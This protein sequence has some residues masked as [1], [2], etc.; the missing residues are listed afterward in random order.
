MN[1][2]DLRKLS[3]AAT[4]LLQYEGH[5]VWC[6]YRDEWAERPCVCGYLDAQDK[7]RATLAAPDRVAEL[8]AEN[9]RL[10][11][12]L[13]SI[14]GNGCCDTCQEAAQVARDTLEGPTPGNPAQLTALNERTADDRG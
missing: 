6:G 8:E 7:L 3:E 12:G 5:H 2:D 4:A 11:A 9:K 1:N 10:R 13:R 14:A